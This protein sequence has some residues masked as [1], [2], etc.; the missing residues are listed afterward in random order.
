MN[1]FIGGILMKFLCIALVVLQN[2][3]INVSFL[4]P[5]PEPEWKTNYTY[6]LSRRDRMG[7]LQP[8]A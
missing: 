8:R 7:R 3:G 6:V 4:K 5:Q 1:S 2:L